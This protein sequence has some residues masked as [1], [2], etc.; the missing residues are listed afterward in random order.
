MPTSAGKHCPAGHEVPGHQSFCGECGAAVEIT[1]PA[2][3]PPVDS[4]GAAVAAP[5]HARSTVPRRIIVAGVAAVL[6][7]VAVGALV[8]RGHGV[9]P[10]VAARKAARDACL[11][12]KSSAECPAAEDS[13]GKLIGDPADSTASGRATPSDL[14]LAARHVCM[15]LAGKA[16]DTASHD[17]SLARVANQYGTESETFRITK[18]LF[19]GVVEELMRSGTDAASRFGV[20]RVTEECTS[21]HPAQ[22]SSG[23]APSAV[24]PVSAGP[25]NG[26]TVFPASL[27]MRLILEVSGC[28]S[29][30]IKLVQAMLARPVTY[31]SS[32]NGDGK[33]VVNGRVEFTVPAK[34]THGMSFEIR[35]P[36]EI[37]Q[38]G[39]D[40]IVTHY[41]GTPAL[42]RAYGCWTGS[43]DATVAL[44][45]TVAR[46]RVEGANNAEGTYGPAAVAYFDPSIAPFGKSQFTSDIGTIGNQ[47]AFYC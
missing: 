32:S 36:W 33:P 35:P 29:C 22:A 40:N 9:D 1:G 28:E 13:N 37:S 30:K 23:K 14:N 12:V 18:K 11:E 24:T 16:L 44:H 34:R 5:A 2:F 19:P 4:G 27:S 31:W 3:S 47:D 21:A 7:A 45:V 17:V 15:D 26:T 8:V 25:P 38:G 20:K 6:L 10:A 41:A 42:Q 39:T 43:T 46:T